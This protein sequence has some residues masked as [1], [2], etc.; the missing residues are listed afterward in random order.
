VN[1]KGVVF[2]KGK[3]DSKERF[4]GMERIL[5][6]ADY[7]TFLDEVKGYARDLKDSGVSTHQLRNI[8]A[9]VKAAK[10]VEE[11]RPL[12]YK[13]AYVAGR[14]RKLQ[15]FCEKLDVLIKRLNDKN[16]NRFQ[17]FFEALIAYHK[18]FGGQ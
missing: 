13:V 1:L 12:R 4:K 8:F 15:P 2:L 18:S 3:S 10:S 6:E 5:E 17:E 16:L 14:E 7:N 11:V 9:K